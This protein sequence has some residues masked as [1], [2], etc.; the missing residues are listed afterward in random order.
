MVETRRNPR[1]RVRMVGSIEFGRGPIDCTV[2]DLS[3][4]G[5]AL[6]VE[7]QTVIPAKFTLAVPGGGLHLPC[8]VVW[9]R[10]YRIGVAFD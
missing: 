6:D 3:I 1:Y 2:R 9:R 7:S 4:S 8:H 5:A 10:P